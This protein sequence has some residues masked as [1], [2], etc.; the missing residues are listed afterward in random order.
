MENGESGQTMQFSLQ[1]DTREAAE[2]VGDEKSGETSSMEPSASLLHPFRELDGRNGDHQP[3]AVKAPS[4]SAAAEYKSAPTLDINDLPKEEATI[5]SY[6]GN[7]SEAFGRGLGEL[8]VVTPAS[9]KED[10]TDLNET[11]KL[12]FENESEQLSP[13]ETTHVTHDFLQASEVKA[14]L[15]EKSAK[16]ILD[17]NETPDVYKSLQDSISSEVTEAQ[18]AKGLHDV[19]MPAVAA[20]A[21]TTTYMKV[22]EAGHEPFFLA[23]KSESKEVLQAANELREIGQTSRPLEGMSKKQGRGDDV[24]DVNMGLE[25]ESAQGGEKTELEREM[26]LFEAS[27]REEQ[28][29]LLGPIRLDQREFQRGDQYVAKDLQ[30]DKKRALESPLQERQRKQ[31][32]RIHGGDEKRKDEEDVCFICFDGGDLVL[33]D[34]RHV[35]LVDNPYQNWSLV[36]CQVSS[37]LLYVLPLTGFCKGFRQPFTTLGFYVTMKLI[38]KLIVILSAHSGL[39]FLF[40]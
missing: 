39:V 4:P 10:V 33:C 14:V 29:R 12:E 2:K 9:A 34:R 36:L 26:E 6:F 24:I 19:Q 16:A 21:A 28:A 37:I 15:L 23:E 1:E 13:I 27:E 22:E 25:E 35:Q 40:V 18:E 3:E 31:S 8:K 17:V 7:E 38:V 5:T 20:V 11:P 32:R 30:N